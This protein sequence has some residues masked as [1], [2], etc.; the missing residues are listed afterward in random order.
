[1]REKNLR[2]RVSECVHVYGKCSKSTHNREICQP[3]QC[4]CVFMFWF[5]LSYWRVLS[6]PTETHTFFAL[7]LYLF[8]KIVHVTLK[9]KQLRIWYAY[10]GSYIPIPCVLF[11]LSLPLSVFIQW[12]NEIPSFEKLQSVHF[13]LMY[14]MNVCMYIYAWCA[15]VCVCVYINV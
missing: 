11:S 5:S 9:R 4:A 1:M 13:V 2:K 7:Y 10:I 12:T 14:S 8:A 6:L 3:I 15:R